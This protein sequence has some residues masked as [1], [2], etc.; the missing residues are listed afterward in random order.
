MNK[1]GRIQHKKKEKIEISIQELAQMFVSDS[2]YE[3][4]YYHVLSKDPNA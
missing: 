4:L 2:N 3:L 1:K